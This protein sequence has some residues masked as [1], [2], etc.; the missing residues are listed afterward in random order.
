MQYEIL[1]QTFD[2]KCSSDIFSES[3][4]VIEKT[5]KKTVIKE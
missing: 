3:M 1:V 2:E 5:E 4:I